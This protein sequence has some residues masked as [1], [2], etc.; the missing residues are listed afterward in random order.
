MS[1]QCNP[2]LRVTRMLGII[3]LSISKTWSWIWNGFI[4][5]LFRKYFNWKNKNQLIQY[6][7]NKFDTGALFDKNILK[8]PF[9]TTFFIRL[10]NVCP[11][12]IIRSRRPPILGTVQ[13]CPERG[14]QRGGPSNTRSLRD[15]SRAIKCDCV[16][17]PA[18]LLHSKR[19]QPLLLLLW[20]PFSSGGYNRKFPPGPPPTMHRLSGLWTPRGVQLS[21]D[22]TLIDFVQ[23]DFHRIAAGNRKIR[24]SNLQRPGLKF[25]GR[26]CRTYRIESF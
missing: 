25:L 14:P 8:G 19:T 15:S 26:S 16:I 9:C 24:I 10:W 1:S 21:V 3:K 6:M 20:S 11:I 2:G 5:I 22:D 13:V 7:H 18:N 23:C 4:C 12:N 17:S